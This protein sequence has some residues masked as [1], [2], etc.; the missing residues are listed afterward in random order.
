MALDKQTGFGLVGGVLGLIVGIVIGLVVVGSDDESP[1]YNFIS[2]TTAAAPTT[3]TTLAP[4]TDDA[5]AVA[6]SDSGPGGS[7]DEPVVLDDSPCDAITKM[8]PGLPLIKCDRSTTVRL[9]QELL[10]ALGYDV[11]VDGDFGPDTQSAVATFQE[12]NGLT[13]DGIVD[14]PTFD[15]L[16]TSAPGDL[17]TG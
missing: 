7:I 16:C 17:C 5:L 11:Q 1:K 2:V 8:P 4:V 3:T 15:L 10:V 12:E 13:M 6:P 14:E 9:V